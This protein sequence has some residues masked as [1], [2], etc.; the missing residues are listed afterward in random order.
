MLASADIINHFVVFMLLLEQ[1]LMLL[2]PDGGF[3]GKA[4]KY[5]YDLLDFLK[6]EGRDA[7]FIVSPYGETL[8]EQ[9]MYNY[10]EEIVTAQGYPFVNM[11]NYYD[12]IG[13]V[14]EEDFADY[15]S[16]T[17]A[18]GAEKCTAFL[19]RYLEAHYSLAHRHDVE[20]DRDVTYASWDEAYRR[21]QARMETARETIRERIENEDYAVKEEEQQE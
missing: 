20:P 12:E 4:D 7:L 2:L 15:G 16:H 14:F 8:K 18:V 1:H 6:A 11:N 10:M 9:Q 13:I 3:G 17:N 21:W 5:A 19:E